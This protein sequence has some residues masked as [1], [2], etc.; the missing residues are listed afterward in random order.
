MRQGLKLESIT[1][2]GTDCRPEGQKQLAQLSGVILNE[3]CNTGGQQNFLICACPAR[4]PPICVQTYR[5]R[6]M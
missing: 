2:T 6:E 5:G 4:P 1:K 3:I